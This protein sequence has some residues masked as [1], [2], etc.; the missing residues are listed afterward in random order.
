MDSILYAISETE[1]QAML[2]KH[3]AISYLQSI[4][5]ST[6]LAP[7]PPFSFYLLCSAYHQSLSLCFTL[8]SSIQSTQLYA[9][10]VQNITSYLFLSLRN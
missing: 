8:H 9:T 2:A 10:V 5:P 4:M 1:F 7:F 3:T 6:N